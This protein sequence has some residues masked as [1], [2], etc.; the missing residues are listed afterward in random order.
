MGAVRGFLVIPSPL[1]LLSGG[2]SIRAARP[3]LA[4]HFRP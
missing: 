1:P 2:P 4:T 3:L